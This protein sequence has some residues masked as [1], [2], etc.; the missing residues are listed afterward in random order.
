MTVLSA[1]LWFA[2]LLLLMHALRDIYGPVRRR[3]VVKMFL[4]P[5][6]VVFLFFKILSCTVAGARTRDIKPFDDK[7]ELLQYDRPSLG[8]FGDFLISVLP[9][10]CLLLTFALLFSWFPVRGLEVPDVPP[11]EWLWNA[12][13]VFFEHLWDFLLGFGRESFES[14]GTVAFWL[15]LYGAVNV[16]MAGA[17]SFKDL[18]YLAVAVAIGAGAAFLASALKISV[19]SRQFDVFATRLFASLRFLLGGG[20]L[21]VVL[22]IFTV[23][24]WRLF[25][26]G[27]EEKK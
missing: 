8:P 13:R 11:F 18:K 27:S 19:G 4:A 26:R 17:P 14:S 1:I 12:P 25:G 3:R 22:S 10:A 5:G 6:V 20:V 9:L 23:G 15:L 16:L 24:A 21:W 2:V 7:A